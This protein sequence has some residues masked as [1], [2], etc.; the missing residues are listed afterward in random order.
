MKLLRAKKVGNLTPF[1]LRNEIL[2]DF[3]LA[4]VTPE[5]VMFSFLFNVSRRHGIVNLN[6]YGPPFSPC[7]LE[8]SVI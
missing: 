7:V 6:G 4:Q 2:S 3:S 1:D 5:V 8:N